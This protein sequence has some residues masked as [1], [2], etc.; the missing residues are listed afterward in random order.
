MAINKGQVLFTGRLAYMVGQKTR[1]AYVIRK[2]MDPTNPQTELQMAFRARMSARVAA[3]RGLAE[4]QREMWRAYAESISGPDFTYDGYTLFLS[5]NLRLENSGQHFMSTPPIGKV[6]DPFA[7]LDSYTAISQQAAG[8][9]T[10]TV[11]Y[12]YVVPTVVEADDG[13]NFGG[14]VLE[15]GLIVGTRQPKYCPSYVI[16]G[17]DLSAAG[18]GTKQFSVDTGLNPALF[19][20]D[21][22]FRI[23]GVDQVGRPAGVGAWQNVTMAAAP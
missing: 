15:I 22:R 3:W 5:G 13:N 17:D 1:N 16:A 2:H 9:S 11:D 8:S 4:Y 10:V 12:S 23:R 20:R 7:L 19:P 14:V 21:Y 6:F 18:G